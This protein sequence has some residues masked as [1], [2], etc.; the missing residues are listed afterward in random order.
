MTFVTRDTTTGNLML[1]GA[2]YRFSGNNGEMCGLSES[3]SSYGE[4]ADVDG[5]H[6]MNHAAIDDF[7]EAA[8][9]MH[10]SVVRTFLSGIGKTNS[11]Q[12][13]LGNFNAAALEGFDYAITKCATA[14]I[15]LICP[16]VDNYNYYGGGKF[17]YCTWN[18]VTPDANATQFF[19]NT[20]VINSYK[21]HISFV[22]NHVNIYTGIAY[23]DDPVFLAWETGNELAIAA[24][25]TQAIIDWTDNI[26]RHIKVTEG[27]KQLVADGWYGIMGPGGVPDA[28]TL[29]NPYVDM[30]SEHSYDQYRTPSYM[31]GMGQTTHSYGKTF[32][33][34]EYTWTGKGVNG[35][36]LPWTLDQMIS[37]VETSPYMDGD[38]FWSLHPQGNYH[39]GGFMLHY[40][41]DD[42]NMITRGNK[43]AN[44]AKVMAS[45]VN[46]A[47]KPGL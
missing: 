30:F 17:T 39:G 23:K 36:G 18:G 46:L 35:F 20:T 24:E 29:S 4:P 12:P 3:T 42:A 47:G 5:L 31:V 38:L 21:A 11:I 13:T 16:M 19:S 40:P 10:A 8:Q 44:H 43:L 22:L 14:G 34:G 28:Q 7:F 9:A 27:A 1:N 32:F 45:T 25:K 26:A 2:R 6:T 15:R 37:A 41:C 33:L